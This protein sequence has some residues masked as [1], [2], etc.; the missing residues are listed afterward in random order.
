MGCGVE[1]AKAGGGIGEGEVRQRRRLGTAATEGGG[2]GSSGLSWYSA[3]EIYSLPASGVA[4]LSTS[5]IGFPWS[6][7]IEELH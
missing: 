5:S 2:C 6:S 3:I 1:A 7:T 4:R